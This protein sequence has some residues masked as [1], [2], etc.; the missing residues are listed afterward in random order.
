MKKIT[1]IVPCYNE[2]AVLDS[3]YEEI[4]KWFNKDYEMNL[5]FVNDG[6]KD[7]TLEMIKGYA[8]ENKLVKYI[9]FSRNFG[10]EAAMQAGLEKCKRFPAT[11]CRD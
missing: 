8:K 1:I 9:S 5:L 10:K 7:K 4:K 11:T 3:F 6:S 2:E